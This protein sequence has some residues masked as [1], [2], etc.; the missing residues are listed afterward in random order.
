MKKRSACNLITGVITACVINSGICGRVELTGGG[1][2][3][4]SVHVVLDGVKRETAKTRYYDMGVRCVI[5]AGFHGPC[6]TA[7]LGSARV[8]S[9][10]NAS[11]VSL[12]L[13][14]VGGVGAVTMVRWAPGGHR[15][16]ASVA[17]DL[18]CTNSTQPNWQWIDVGFYRSGRYPTSTV[19]LTAT[20]TST[21]NTVQVDASWVG[22]GWRTPWG[23][24]PGTSGSTGAVSLTYADAIVLRGR[25]SNARVLYDVKGVVPITA[26]I[27]ELPAGLS[28]ARSA[29]GLK[30]NPGVTADIG[31]GD[32][33]TC[34]NTLRDKE[35]I[36]DAMTITAMVR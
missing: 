26:R 8:V 13:A 6:A 21:G 35:R 32:T 27:D 4:R 10:T 30:L 24:A 2:V 28:C 11:D 33:I 22:H 19:L 16:S 20:D 12:G 1:S 31:Q 3:V 25:N 5:C 9:K 15:E 17:L 7:P 29:D 23:A 18:V 34:T 36:D 14:H